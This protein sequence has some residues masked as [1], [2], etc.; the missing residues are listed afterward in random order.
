M[1]VRERFRAQPLGVN[2]S[3]TVG[4]MAIGGILA[5]TAGTIT[6]TDADGTV[7]VDAIPVSAGVYTPLPFLFKTN[8]GGTI[9]LAGGAS[10]T[11]GV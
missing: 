7:L 2:A 6:M 5:K 8:A 4:G 11:L 9:T 3:T 10:G 1:Y